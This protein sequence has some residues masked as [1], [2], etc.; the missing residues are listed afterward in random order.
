[1][2]PPYLEVLTQYRP[3]GDLLFALNPWNLADAANQNCP[4]A[5]ASVYQYLASQGATRV[6][7]A[8]GHRFT[9]SP[10]LNQFTTSEFQALLTLI[11]S[12]PS[13]N[14]VVVHAERTGAPE[15]FFNL[16]NIDG[17]VWWVDA[18]MNPRVSTNERLVSYAVSFNHMRNFSYTRGPFSASPQP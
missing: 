4:S 15:H 18:G 2:A 12:G 5:A 1:M 10:E 9:I 17:S 7:A 11:Q 3:A 13:G 6:Q 14:H 16:V 8:Q